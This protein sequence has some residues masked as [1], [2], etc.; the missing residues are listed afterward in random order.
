MSEEEKIPDEE[1]VEGN[2]LDAKPLSET[3]YAVNPDGSVSSPKEA[4]KGWDS[5]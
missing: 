1:S 4:E 3:G 2:V 5:K